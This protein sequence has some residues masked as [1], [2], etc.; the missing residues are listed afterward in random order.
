MGRLPVHSR[1]AH[2]EEAHALQLESINCLYMN[3]ASLPN[4][5]ADLRELS[6][7]NRVH[8]IRISEPSQFSDQ[9]LAI[10]GMSF[11]RN[12]RKTGIGGGLVVYIR[13]CL[14]VHQVHNLEFNNL[15]ESIWCSVRLSTTSRCLLGVTYRKPAADIGYDSRVLERISCSTRLGFTHIL[16][17]GNFNLLRVNFAEHTYI[18][19]ENSTEAR[20][21]NLIEDLRLCENVKSAIRWRNSQTPSRLDCVFTNEEFL[22]ENLSILAPLRKSEHAVIAFSFVTKTELRYPTNNM[23][24]NFKRLN[25]SALQDYLQQVD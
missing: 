22:V 11:F 25:A 5:M 7:A 16:I 9:E 8:L 19:C 13:S 18:E 3:A 4:K 2:T 21:F 1:K 14:E 23:R 15:Q 17:L 24:W 10:P 12:D 6:N 20:F